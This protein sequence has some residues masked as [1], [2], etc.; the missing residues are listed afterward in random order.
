MHEQGMEP[1]DGR[2]GHGDGLHEGSR[3]ALQRN[4]EPQLRGGVMV[5]G[6]PISGEIDGEVDPIPGQGE[7][8]AVQ[9]T[10]HSGPL[11]D[12]QTL[13]SYGEIDPSF[14]ERVFRMTEAE[15]ETKLT[16][17][18]RLAFTQMFATVAGM[19]GV[20]LIGV[21]G[22]LAGYLTISAGH[23]EGAVFLAAPVM[24]GAPRIIEAI[25]GRKASAEQDES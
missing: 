16:V 13:K 1:N 10:F 8:F 6:R 7:L 15:L 22:L 19:S 21:G 5:D 18:K 24:A 12:G 17:T 9:Q 3:A 4:H 2:G 14:P 23:P 25:N 20:I 11:P